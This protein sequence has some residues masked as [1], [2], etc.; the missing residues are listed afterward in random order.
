MFSKPMRMLNIIIILGTIATPTLAL[1]AGADTKS[2]SSTAV[3]AKESRYGGSKKTRFYEAKNLIAQKKFNEAYLLLT[4]LPKKIKDEADR[5]NLL[6]FSARK[7]GQ[8]NKAAA[9]YNNALSINSMHKGALEYQGE[10]FLTLGQT[11][12]A[13]NNL[14]ML[15]TLCPIGCLELTKLKQAI[16]NY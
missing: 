6:G 14:Q 7:S 15:K 16:N 4:T 2:S 9:H 11:A 5:Q 3:K 13:Q 12:E 1:G 10:L 8:L